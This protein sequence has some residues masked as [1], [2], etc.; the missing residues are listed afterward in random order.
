MAGFVTSIFNSISRGFVFAQI[1]RFINPELLSSLI[2]FTIL[3]FA[4]FF[5]Y[6]FLEDFSKY[7]LVELVMMHANIGIAA[8]IFFSSSERNKKILLIIMGVS[9]SVSVIVM[10]FAF[11]AWWMA[12]VFVLI[13]YSRMITPLKDLKKV[14]WVGEMV[15]TMVRFGFYMLAGLLCMLLNEYAFGK[16]HALGMLVWGATYYMAIYLLRNKEAMI[17]AFFTD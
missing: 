9:Y 2:Y 8:A 13:I 4:R 6:S 15:L 11:G 17:K 3:I 5:D 14:N 16:E 12:F 7:I 10:A 1:T